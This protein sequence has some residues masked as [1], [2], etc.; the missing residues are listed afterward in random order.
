M[1]RVDRAVPARSSACR[2]ERAYL[3]RSDAT[4]RKAPRPRYARSG[5][6]WQC[7]SHTNTSCCGMERIAYRRG[8]RVSA[9]RGGALLR[10]KR[11]LELPAVPADADHLHALLAF[12][13]D[14]AM[15]QTVGRWKIYCARAL[16]V[17]WQENFFDHRIRRRG[18]GAEAR[19]HP[20]ESG[21]KG[22]LREGGRV[23][24]EMGA[25]RG[26]GAF[27]ACRD[28]PR[29]LLGAVLRKKAPPLSRRR[30]RCN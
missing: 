9:S 28:G 12:P 8:D 4:S 22:A 5:S 21:G 14:R 25:V 29:H 17:R 11:I 27:L 30:F 6:D 2:S 18:A 23:G 16:S 13:P 15:A 3:L 10:R 24:L 7:I 1:S 19:V 26:R 20:A